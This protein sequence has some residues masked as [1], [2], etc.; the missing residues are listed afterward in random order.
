MAYAVIV[1]QLSRI[2]QQNKF[3]GNPVHNNLK[4]YFLKKSIEQK[5]KIKKLN[6]YKI[7]VCKNKLS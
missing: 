6:L 7:Q 3:V 5:K 2:Y 4:I 1:F